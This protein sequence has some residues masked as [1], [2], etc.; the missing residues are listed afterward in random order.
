MDGTDNAKL[1]PTTTQENKLNNPCRY[2]EKMIF[3]VGQELIK[4]NGDK[5]VIEEIDEDM[6]YYTINEYEVEGQ[7]LLDI[8]VAEV[9]K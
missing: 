8:F 9:I 1:N 5:V 4:S 2:G 7:A 3:K 6:I